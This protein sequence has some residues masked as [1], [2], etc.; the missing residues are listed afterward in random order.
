MDLSPGVLT[1]KSIFY[2]RDLTGNDN[3][4]YIPLYDNSAHGSESGE[5]N[6]VHIAFT[7]S[8]KINK[9]NTLSWTA[10]LQAFY[11][12]DNLRSK[13]Q[14]S[15]Q[16]LPNGNVI[17]NWGPEGAVTE[18][19]SNGEV[20]FHA[21][22]GSGCLELGVQNYRG[23]QYNWAGLP[24]EE[25]AIVALENEETTTVYVSWDGDTETEIWRFYAIEGVYS[26]RQYL[27]ESVRESFETS[28][29]I[30]GVAGFGLRALAEALD[31]MKER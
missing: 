27:G 14:G 11:S 23:F 4:E 22:M 15:T 16:M 25:P 3:V 7:S 8:G 19:N 12:P 31:E 26:E 28:F 29:E 20:L 18:Y 1:A 6:E 21:Y 17:M 10:D 2:S 5:G 9:L 30:L 13:S 24:N